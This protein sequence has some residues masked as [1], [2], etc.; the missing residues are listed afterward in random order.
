MVTINELDAYLEPDKATV[1]DAEVLVIALIKHI[2]LNEES[3]SKVGAIYNNNFDGILTTNISLIHA[4]NSLP[5]WDYITYYGGRKVKGDVLKILFLFEK[6]DDL[7]FLNEQCDL[8]VD[9]QRVPEDIKSDWIAG[10]KQHINIYNNKNDYIGV[11]D[12]NYLRPMVRFHEVGSPKPIDIF[13]YE[14]EN[15]RL[16]G[17]YKPS[18]EKGM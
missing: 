2:I 13:I 15:I 9:C 6:Q 7:R 4:I 12:I 18:D 10:K 8:V 16:R 14:I 11:H 1:S 5:S 17:L 3:M